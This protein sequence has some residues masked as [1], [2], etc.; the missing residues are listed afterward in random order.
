MHLLTL[1]FLAQYP[2]L[3]I[4]YK[5]APYHVV[6]HCSTALEHA[7]YYIKC[8]VMREGS[9]F[10]CGEIVSL[11]RALTTN[12]CAQQKKMFPQCSRAVVVVN[13]K[14]TTQLLALNTS[15]H[16]KHG[17]NQLYSILRAS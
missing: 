1:I 6:K 7:C 10:D 5:Q 4:Y 16:R 14:G 8:I 11:S 3:S 2:T 15:A 13:T 12:R 17:Q 9:A